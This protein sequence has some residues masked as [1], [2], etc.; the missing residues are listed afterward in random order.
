MGFRALAHVGKAVSIFGSARTAAR[1]PGVRRRRARAR[2]PA[3]R[4]G[5]RDHHRRRAR[6]SWRRPTAAPA[7]P[8]CPRSAS[9]SSSRTSRRS[10]ST[11]TSPLTFHYF[12]TRK[13]M[14]VRYAS[15]LRGL[16]RRLR[17]ARRAVRGRDA[18]PDAQDPPLPDRARRAP[19]TGRGCS[20]GCAARCSRAARST[21]TTSSGC[22]SPTTSTRSSRSSRPPTT[23]AARGLA[24]SGRYSR[25][26][27]THSPSRRPRVRRSRPSAAAE[28]GL[29]LVGARAVDDLRRARASGPGRRR[30]ARRRRPGAR[31]PRAAA[32]SQPRSSAWAA[33]RSRLACSRCSSKRAAGCAASWRRRAIGA[34]HRE[35]D[36]QERRRPTTMISQVGTGWIT[37]VR[38]TGAPRASRGARPTLRLTRWRALSTVLQ[39]QSSCS[40]MP[41][42]S[43]RRGRARA[44][45]T[46]ARRARSTGRRRASAAPRRRSPG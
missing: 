25:R 5:L 14:F 28:D 29:V 26:S 12:F 4:G 36:D 37:A 1:P 19:P 23:A 35:H 21:R 20:T 13:V 41:C 45:A 44:R 7:T 8:A 9:T 33:A 34:A 31:R 30:R 46:R 16:P 18:A 3:R 39:S 40:P 27:S 38:P 32:R 17:H 6:G 24:P 43:G 10:T 42:R 2:P 11:S 22:T 15:A